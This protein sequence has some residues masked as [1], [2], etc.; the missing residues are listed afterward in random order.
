LADNG[1][2]PQAGEAAVPGVLF[3]GRKWQVV[4]G[5]VLALL[6]VAVIVIPFTQSGYWVRLLTG[7]FMY[8]CL[9]SSL[10]IMLGYTGYADFGNVVY[11]GLGAY[12]TGI[13]MRMG[14]PFPLAIVAGGLLCACFAGL[15]GLP[16]LRLRGNYF[17]IATLGLS[18]A[19]REIVR[20]MTITG[21]GSGLSVPI[22]R[23]PPRVF[24]ALI[25]FLMLFLLVS[26]MTISHLISRSRFGYALRAI[27]ADEQGASVMGIDT[28]RQKIKAWVLCAFCSGLVGGVYALW[29]VYFVP[30]DVFNIL[31]SVKYLVMVYLG[32]I[33]TVWG[34]VIGAFLLEYV[35]DYVWGRFLQ[36]HVG[37]LGLAVILIILFM[38]RGFLHMLR[39]RVRPWISRLA[40][41]SERS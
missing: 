28:T 7:M 24:N 32:G 37:I 19:T 1:Q 21:G 40:T 39:T 8:A 34:P 27:K 9:A 3:G 31:I 6:G 18:Q 12:T 36:L 11:F 41:R 15:V 33:G 30:S 26:Y 17:A 22:L 4:K 38:P 14:A 2:K 29:F 13:T 10:N 5:A 16:I 20:N 23:L 35:S 25:Y